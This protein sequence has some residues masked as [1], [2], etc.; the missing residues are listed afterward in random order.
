M[1]DPRKVRV[2]GR[3]IQAKGIRNGDDA[4]FFIHTNGAGIGLPEVKIVGPGGVNQ[5]VDMKQ[6]KSHLYECHYYPTKEGRYVIMVKF[7]KV[8]VP[9]APYEVI[10]GPRSS[11]SII[12]HGP[13]LHGGVIGYAATFVVEMNGETG[14][15]GFSVAGPSQ[16]EIECQD[17]GD[18]SALVRYLPTVAGEYAIH[19]LCDNDDIPNSPFIAQIL[20]KSNFHPELV[21]CSGVGV[22]SNISLGQEVEFEVD[23]SEAGK[24][25][26]QINV[27]QRHIWI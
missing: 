4:T 6:V 11:S 17:N 22:E 18:G 8:D 23:T 9:K 5:N 16:A 24:A 26:L 1:C 12:A 10:V 19:I 13:G 2:R 20:P 25:L 15:L 14:S 3:G 21:K 7:G 27:S